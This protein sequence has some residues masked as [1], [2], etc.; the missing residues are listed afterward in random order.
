MT[1]SEPDPVTANNEYAGGY[2]VQR[3]G[4]RGTGNSGCFIA[5]AAYGSYLEPEVMVLR[6][7]RDRYL[8]AF[9]A[10]R[11]F[12]A[13]Y[14]RV[15][16]PVA[17]YIRDRDGLRAI[18]RAALTPVIYGIKYPGPAGGLMLT[19]CALPVVMRRRRLRAGR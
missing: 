3:T 2:L 13:W 14:S 4:S 10:G 5:T 11:Q 6:H 8:L 16:P 17:N 15:S 12:V 1:G 9:A 18:T 7:F 19:L